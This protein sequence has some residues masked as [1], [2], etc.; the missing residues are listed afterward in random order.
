MSEF[1]KGH[2]VSIS[3]YST[4]PN[5]WGMDEAEM[6]EFLQTNEKCNKWVVLD[7]ECSDNYWD[8]YNVETGMV[9][10]GVCDSQFTTI[11]KPGGMGATEDPY[12]S[13]PWYGESA[14]K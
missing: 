8:V 2:I 3:P 5:D 7:L 1:K 6:Q 9:V 14:N 13:H 11:M 10:N 12:Q 4:C